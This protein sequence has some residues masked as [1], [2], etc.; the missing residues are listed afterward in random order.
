MTGLDTERLTLRQPH[1][2]DLELVHR[3][4]ADPETNVHNPHGPHPDRD[5]SARMLHACLERW[6]ATGLD[7]FV[8]EQRSTGE[9]IGFAGARLVD[10]D[11]EPVLELYYRFQPSAWGQG[12][13]TEAARA[14]IRSARARYP[15]RPLVVRTRPDNTPSIR[16]ARKL[17][18][19]LDGPGH[20]D[21]YDDVRYR[22]P[23]VQELPAASTVPDGPTVPETLR[24]A[25]IDCWVE[26]TNAGGA[27][28]FV[29]PTTAAE[30]TPE[31]DRSLEA[32]RTGAHTLVVVRFGQ[33]LA[34]FGF[35][36]MNER[37]A[38]R[39]WATVRAL[40]V[41]PKWQGRGLGRVL[42][43]GLADVGRAHG[44][45]RLQL[46]YRGGLGL[47]AFY[48]HCG[49]VEVGRIPGAIRVSPGDDRDQVF[50]IRNL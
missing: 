18:F 6:A 13:A 12:F 33:Q 23:V 46:D 10:V 47:G 25:M 42:L 28:G 22:L 7:Y 9:P 31:L 24:A 16:T 36:A 17:G 3:I 1:E 49:Y 29:A 44:L 40:Q 38:F 35:L 8:V 5:T 2:H 21:G 27:I 39:H 45:E 14:V 34:G 4:H 41:H 43:D 37:A 15:Q 30:V 19:V 20:R 26:A 11:G 32:V 50:M 48:R